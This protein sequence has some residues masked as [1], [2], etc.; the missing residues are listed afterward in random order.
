MALTDP[1]LKVLNDL[2]NG[3]SIS[4]AAKA[5]GLHR[6]TITNWRRHNT[7]FAS[8]LSEALEER[9]LHYREELESLTLKAIRV[10]RTILHDPE[11]SPSLRFRAAQ[12]VLRLTTPSPAAPKTEIPHKPAQPQP[13]RRPVEPG[14]NSQCSCNS[15][16]KYKRCCANKPIPT[17]QVAA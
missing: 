15:G 9:A 17:A 2:V 7:E 11:A 14:R 10:L 13:V 5:A 8:V 16:L 4:E 3:I 6:N 1:Q 12:T